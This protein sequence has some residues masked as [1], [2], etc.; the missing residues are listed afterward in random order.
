MRISFRSIRSR[1]AITVGSVLLACR[2]VWGVD[3]VPFDMGVS[4]LRQT[5]KK[6]QT[7]ASILHVVAHPDD[8]DGGLLA[9]SARR[10]GVRTMLFSITRGEG[11]ANLISSHFFDDLGA[12]R[13]LEHSQA[14]R[15]Y[16][17]ELFYSRAADYGYSK[18][19]AEARS[20]WQEGEP[21]LADLV[22][23]VRRERPTVIASRF[24]GDSRD[25]H[26]HHQMAGVI[27][28][29]VFDAAADPNRFPEQLER[30]LR[31]WKARKLY[32]NNIRPQWRAEDR[33]AWTIAISTGDYDALLGRSYAQV[34]RY[35]LG[36]Q[37]SQGI[38]GHAGRVGP[39]ESYYRIRQSRIP[40]Y[41]PSREASMFDAIDTSIRGLATIAGPMPH[42]SLTNGLNRIHMA[43]ESAVAK[44][45]STSPEACVPDLVAGLEATRHLIEQLRRLG[46]T[47]DHRFELEFQLRR[48][49]AEFRDAIRTALGLHLESWAS[50]TPQQSS[51][52]FFG[53]SQ[54]GFQHATPGQTIHV[55]T[56]L[57]NRSRIPIS[58]KTIEYHTPQ[59]WHVET[60]ELAETELN[61]NE[62]AESIT[63]IE[64]G[65]EAAAT[66]PYW[67]RDS[68]REPLYRLLDTNHRQRP[69]PADP[70]HCV[71]SVHVLGQ[72]VQM[73]C[74]IAVRM[75]HPILGNV[76]YP[77]SVVPEVGLM[78]STTSGVVPAGRNDYDVSVAV[79]S[80]AKDVATGDIS[81][82]L[83]VGWSSAPRSPPFRIGAR[84]R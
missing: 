16:G 79:R 28:Q 13:T 29:L 58:V 26:G 37:R 71:V 39:N 2:A 49:E 12:L 60:G 69:L 38:S 51:R 72:D 47:D 63:T 15:Y 61:Y 62:V 3:P 41:Q 32:S 40:D 73:G 83:P 23:V 33:D 25:G 36:F 20:Q 1:S 24:R 7:T 76:E 53:G 19:L 74:P 31:P 50:S 21:I 18:T 35:G 77:L 82:D 81:L 52:S 5:L 78:F 17:N 56:R 64:L 43:A 9:F 66:R 55:K 22:E 70:A 46:L 30:G 11:G 42:S 48:K 75:K 57:V 54:S 27:S 67:F 80:D 8:E 10:E 14:A 59:S 6:L 34:A 68:I 65:D 45:D 84:G 44:F 4:G